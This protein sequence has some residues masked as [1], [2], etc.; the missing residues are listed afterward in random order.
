MALSQ[1]RTGNT[2]EMWEF[3]THHGFDW[4]SVKPGTRLMVEAVFR[5]KHLPPISTPD[6]D[7]LHE[8]ELSR[9]KMESYRLGSE[10]ITNPVP[11]FTIPGDAKR[12]PANAYG[13]FAF[14]DDRE[15]VAKLVAC[16]TKVR[17]E[18]AAREKAHEEAKAAEKLKRAEE[19]RL[20]REERGREL[21][22]LAAEQGISLEDLEDGIDAWN[23][24][25]RGRYCD[26]Q[27]LLCGRLLTDPKSIVTG[28]GP[29]CVK[30]VPHI[31]AAARAKVIDVGRMRW[32]GERL[33]K[34]FRRAGIDELVEVVNEA[35]E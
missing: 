12:R 32:D 23:R 13:R 35:T 2:T 3:N 22:Q 9:V 15:Q 28:V 27:C 25:R 11:V 10:T 14:A 7:G 33:V 20:R 30:Q 16:L 1:T 8:V 26:S 19:A 29:E 21:A 6:A 4:T 18:E 24:I 31:A 34:R 17:A 5:P